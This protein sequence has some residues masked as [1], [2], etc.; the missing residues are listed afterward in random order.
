MIRGKTAPDLVFLLRLTLFGFWLFMML[1][2]SNSR[3]LVHYLPVLYSCAFL[4]GTGAGHPAE[5]PAAAPPAA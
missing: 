1:W 3:Y 5:S 2:E 4:G